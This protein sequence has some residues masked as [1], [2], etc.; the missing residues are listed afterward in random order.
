MLY[1]YDKFLKFFILKKYVY[2]YIY[3]IIY[4][5]YEHSLLFNC[6]QNYKNNFMWL[7]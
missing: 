7:V 1:K 2:I 6:F 5:I 4:I 3:Y